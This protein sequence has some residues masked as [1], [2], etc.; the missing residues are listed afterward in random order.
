MNVNM[1]THYPCCIH[2]PTHSMKREENYRY[3]TAI[4]EMADW[5]YTTYIRTHYNIKPHTADKMVQ[6]LLKYTDL[7]DGV[8][9]ALEDDSV[10][11]GGGTDDTFARNV[12]RNINHM[13]L[14][15]ALNEKMDVSRLRKKIKR[16]VT[17]NGIIKTVPQIV[18]GDEALRHTILKGLNLNQKALGS[19]EPIRDS[20]EIVKYVNKHMSNPQTH[21]NYFFKCN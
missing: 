6:K 14:L 17:T 7:I 16:R 1:A 12:N 9:F 13:H 18:T 20:V 10:I 11:H 8:Y 19:I 15:F 4:A 3:N 21:H 5:Q 2:Y